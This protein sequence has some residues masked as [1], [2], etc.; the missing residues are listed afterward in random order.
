M[1]AI[2]EQL[3]QADGAVTVPDA[4]RRRTGTDTLHAA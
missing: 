3:Q 1:A 4:L 2:L